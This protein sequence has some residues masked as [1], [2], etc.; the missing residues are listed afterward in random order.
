M[1]ARPSWQLKKFDTGGYSPRRQDPLVD[2]DGRPRGLAHQKAGD[3]RQCPCL[4]GTRQGI[5]TSERAATGS[6]ALGALS[7]DRATSLEPG[8]ACCARGKVPPGDCKAP[9]L[10]LNTSSEVDWRERAPERPAR[11]PIPQ[12]E[13]GRVG[14]F[15]EERLLSRYSIP[16]RFIRLI[17][18]TYD[19]VEVHYHLGFTRSFNPGG[20]ER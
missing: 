3:F 16:I 2:A 4:C 8:A 15:F 6:I 20:V 12:G 17:D 1:H 11:G 5:V 19:E 10:N 18:I 7:G 9:Q 14:R 13:H